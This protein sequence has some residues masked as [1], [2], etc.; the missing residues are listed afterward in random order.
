VGPVR[1]LPVR[2]RPTVRCRSLTNRSERGPERHVG[3]RRLKNGRR[4]DGGHSQQQGARTTDS[5]S[6]PAVDLVEGLNHHIGNVTSGSHLPPQHDE[7]IRHAIGWPSP[8]PAREWSIRRI[9]LAGEYTRVPQN[10]PTDPAIQ[11]R[12]SATCPSTTERQFSGLSTSRAPRGLSAA[13]PRGRDRECGRHV[14]RITGVVGLPS[15]FAH[16]EMS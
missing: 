7:A 11:W 3:D 12:P 1:A 14:R 5:T 15:S 8:E 6:G 16:Y 13:R 4:S 10:Q 2:L 9:V